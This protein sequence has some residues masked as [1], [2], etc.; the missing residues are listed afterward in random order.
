MSRLPPE[1][2]KAWLPS[3]GQSFSAMS[4]VYGEETSIRAVSNSATSSVVPVMVVAAI[5]IP[6][7]LRSRMAANEASAVGSIRSVNTAQVAYA[8]MYTENGFARDLATLGGTGQNA[9]AAHALLLDSTLACPGGT[10]ENWCT[11]SGYKFTVRGSCMQ[12]QCFQYVVVATPESTS[13]GQRSFCSMKDGLIRF[14]VGPPVTS[15]ISATECKA[16][17]VIR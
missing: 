7:L 2:A 8:A 14:K 13:T 17:A 5:A 12:G 11:R 15:A 9:T 3:A 10:A 1:I 4:A 16:W 6:N